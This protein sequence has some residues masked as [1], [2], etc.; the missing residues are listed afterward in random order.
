MGEKL[1]NI[2][3]VEFK[4]S[5]PHQETCFCIFFAVDCAENKGRKNNR[6]YY[7]AFVSAALRQ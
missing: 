7:T 3:V 4:L 1:F 2:Q 5:K 6:H